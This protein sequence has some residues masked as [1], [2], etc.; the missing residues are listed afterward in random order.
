[1]KVGA[2]EETI[3]V[4]GETPIVDVQSAQR[5][6]VVSK[7]VITA[8]PTA[9]GYSRSLALVPGVVGGHA[10]RRDRS[11]CRARSARTARCSAGRANSEG[12][13]L[14]D[15]LLHRGAAGAARRTISPTRGTRR[16]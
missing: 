6:T 12:R 8:L 10:G 11:L 5:Q 9:G 4:T 2:L 16:K 7:D 1:M 13:T 15:G 3:T 14:L